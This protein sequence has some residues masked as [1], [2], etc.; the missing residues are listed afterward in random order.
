M[1]TSS[2][3]SAL[4]KLLT[5]AEAA[6]LLRVSVATL[7]RWASQRRGPPYLRLGRHAWYRPADLASFVD[8][9]VREPVAECDPSQNVSVRSNR[10]FTFSRGKQ[11]AK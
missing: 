4:P 5:R 2:D 9:Q 11:T 10:R 6:K 8:S 1:S 3:L 7:A